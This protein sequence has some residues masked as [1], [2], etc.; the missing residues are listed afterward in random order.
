[1]TF[2]ENCASHGMRLAKVIE[3]S[4]GTQYAFCVGPKFD[5]DPDSVEGSV[6][7]GIIRRK[8]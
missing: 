2:D 6:D 5:V 3:D 4:I 1:M 8:P 7:M